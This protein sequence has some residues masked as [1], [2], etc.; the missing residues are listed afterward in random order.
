M[1]F[2]GDD[3]TDDKI[4]VWALLRSGKGTLC[5][6]LKEG[7][8]DWEHISVGELLRKEVA[9]ESEKVICCKEDCEFLSWILGYNRS[10]LHQKW[11]V[12]G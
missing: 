8:P 6:K 12:I 4:F 10:E 7:Y 3:D 2:G 1:V 11:A 5:Q 9:K